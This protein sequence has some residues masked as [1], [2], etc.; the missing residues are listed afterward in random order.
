MHT[1]LRV[2]R[3]RCVW[4]FSRGFQE[5]WVAPDLAAQRRREWWRKMDT[6]KTGIKEDYWDGHF[7]SFSLS[8]YLFGC[9]CVFLSCRIFL[10]K[11]KKLAASWFPNRESHPEVNH[12]MAFRVSHGPLM[13]LLQLQHA[14]HGWS[15]PT[16]SQLMREAAPKDDGQVL[17]RQEQRCQDH[18]RVHD[19][20]H[21][22]SEQQPRWCCVGSSA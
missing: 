8:V 17:C 4:Y 19:F 10:Y 3:C 1:T 11:W 2:S 16:G 5:P 6:K 12:A 14:G 13:G 21:C 22:L 7:L 18:E 9:V 20:G 15:P